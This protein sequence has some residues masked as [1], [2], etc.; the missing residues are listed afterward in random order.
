MVVKSLS[1]EQV[2]RY[3]GFPILWHGEEVG[4]VDP[5]EPLPEHVRQEPYSLPQGF[6][7]VTLSSSDVENVVRFAVDQWWLDV[8]HFQINYHMMYPHTESELQ[9]S[10]RTKNNKLIGVAVANCVSI[11][12]GETSM[13]CLYPTI[14]YHRKYQNN[15]LFYIL[16]KELMRRANL[17]NI[18][19]F[20]IFKN[21]V[22]KSLA[23]MTRWKYEFQHPATS[24][25]PSSPKTPGWRR[26]TSEDVPSA[27][28]LINKWSSQFEIRQI[29]RSEEECSYY[30]LNLFPTANVRVFT[31]VV[32]NK[33]KNITDLVRYLIHTDSQGSIYATYTVVIATQSPTKQLIIDALVCARKAYATYLNI[34]QHNIESD[35]LSSLSFYQEK[36]SPCHLYNYKHHE[37]PQHKFWFTL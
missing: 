17:Y 9:F 5:I 24:Q 30:F 31:Y 26:M 1:C 25:L 34:Y 8:N 18:N 35:V 20:V 3:K 14:A 27:L 10:I 12:I 2:E 21:P 37:I 23:Y 29:F 36:H 22:F 6:H 13:K 28:A 7:W 4:E 19:M 33:A 15:R 32:Q 16:N 11:C